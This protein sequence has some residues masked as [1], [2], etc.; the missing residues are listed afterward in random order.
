MSLN[1]QEK[2]VNSFWV[3]ILLVAVGIYFWVIPKNS[4]AEAYSKKKHYNL[5][6]TSRF[7]AVGF[8][9]IAISCVP[10][11][12]SLWFDTPWICIICVIL[13]VLGTSVLHDYC[14]QAP[15]L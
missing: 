13:L 10:V 2:F 7:L 5:K 1:N 11:L 12:I 8:W 6:K 14:P 4:I 9:I 15:C 3:I